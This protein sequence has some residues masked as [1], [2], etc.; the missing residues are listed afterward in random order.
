[1]KKK[2]KEEANLLIYQK[3]KLIS[4]KKQTTKI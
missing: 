2:L 1:M 3:E 4:S